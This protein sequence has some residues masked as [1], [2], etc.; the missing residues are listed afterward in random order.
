[1]SD[2]LRELI[3]YIT[4]IL[5]IF[6]EPYS[7]EELLR[8]AEKMQVVYEDAGINTN[9]GHVGHYDLPGNYYGATLASGNNK[10]CTS[11]VYLDT[12]HVVN[13]P[14]PLWK[15]ILA[16][17]WSH[18]AQGRACSQSGS[19]LDAT[20]AAFAVL[21]NA[22]EYNALLYALIWLPANKH[23]DKVEY[24]LADDDGLFETNLGV[25]D[26]RVAWNLAR[27]I[28]K[29][30]VEN[31]DTRSRNPG[32]GIGSVWLGPSPEAQ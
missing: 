30:G 7:Q 15:Y 20:M 18:V 17:E 25:I 4:Y 28:A 24:L 3:F 5:F 13:N 12:H 10:V 8:Y 32:L 31:E 16:H 6:Q 1:M 19:E 29:V 21:G 9:T 2:A 23:A 26:A 27:N 14:K 11:Q 22:K